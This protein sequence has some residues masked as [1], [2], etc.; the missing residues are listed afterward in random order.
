MEGREEKLNL[1]C[2][3]CILYFSNQSHTAQS[4]PARSS[5]DPSFSSTTFNL[6]SNCRTRLISYS[7]V[8][9]ERREILHIQGTKILNDLHKF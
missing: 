4:E 8:R 2:F 6:G 5:A 1:S 7:N 9:L 3:V